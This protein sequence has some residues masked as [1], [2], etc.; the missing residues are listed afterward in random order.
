MTA[1]PDVLVQTII[2]LQNLPSLSQNAKLSQLVRVI[3]WI[4]N[5]FVVSQKKSN[6]SFLY[7]YTI[8]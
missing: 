4:N 8:E 3:I 6:N 2:E 5:N 1:V 7:F